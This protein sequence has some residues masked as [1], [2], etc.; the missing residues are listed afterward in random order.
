MSVS[1]NYLEHMFKEQ[2]K[3]FMSAIKDLNDSI[4][5]L[6]AAVSVET[7]ALVDA[8]SKAVPQIDDSADIEAAV[9]RVQAATKALTDS[10]APVAPA[11]EPAP[12]EPAPAA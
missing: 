11:P 2:R 7:A 5:A 9:A 4:D 12:V 3:Y 8:I 10:V 6:V 1:R